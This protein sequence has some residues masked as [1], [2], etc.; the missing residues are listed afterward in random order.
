MNYEQFQ[1]VVISEGTPFSIVPIEGFENRNPS[2]ETSERHKAL[3]KQTRNWFAN[4]PN[5]CTKH[6]KISKRKGFSR[7]K[8]ATIPGEV[9]D[10]LAMTEY[11]IETRASA[12][13]W[14]EDISDY[15]EYA[16]FS[17]GL[18]DAIGIDK[19]LEGLENYLS[20]SPIPEEKRLK[21]VKYFEI[22][23]NS[24]VDTNKSRMD[25]QRVNRVYK[26]WLSALPDISLLKEHKQKLMQGYPQ[27]VFIEIERYNPYLDMSIAKVRSKKSM[28]KDLLKLTQ[29][30]LGQL[31][32][33]IYF[34]DFKL[35]E[36]L[37]HRKESKYENHRIK[38][39]RLLNTLEKGEIKYKKVIEKWLK[40]EQKFIASEIDY[41]TTH[42]K[43]QPNNKIKPT[44]QTSKKTIPFLSLFGSNREKMNDTLSVLKG[45]RL[46]ALDSENNWIYKGN[47]SSI[48]ACFEALESLEIIK[49]IA[50]KALLQR[51][52]AAKIN[53]EGNDKLFRNPYK[54]KDYLTFSDEFKRSLKKYIK[55]ETSS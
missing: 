42:V 15:I 54:D 3:R 35:D 2:K 9:I 5:C 44:K 52:V 19:Y 43:P 27:D 40:N 18:P 28:L 41:Y 32:S 51:C 25:M 13:N 12:D 10:K 6:R 39:E 55:V 31:K 45:T 50:N 1:I 16:C 17:F 30:F 8:Y 21:L 29:W 24:E 48:V 34:K 37:K 14:F 4:F 53:F 36:A 38:Q 11:H 20:I 46:E 47:K 23:K 26:K 22:R 49:V 33:H 7:W